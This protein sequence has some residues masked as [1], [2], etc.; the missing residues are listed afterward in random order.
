MAIYRSISDV[1]DNFF[2]GV[3]VVIPTFNQ[4]T[5]CK[6][7]IARLK[8]FG[9]NNFIILDNGSTYQPFLEWLNHS[10]Y[11]AVIDFRNPGPRDF[12]ANSEIYSRLPKNFIVTDPDLE[13]PE[14]IPI[15]LVSDLLEISKK[16]GWH[17]LGLGLSREPADKMVPLVNDWEKNYWINILAHTPSGDP[18]YEAKVDTTFA[19]YNKDFVRGPGVL[20]PEGEFFTA[21]R[22]CGKYICI[23]LGWYLDAKVPI[24]EHSYYFE[25]AAKWASTIRETKRVKYSLIAKIRFLVSRYFP[26]KELT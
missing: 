20:E 18:I 1:P 12:W 14:S 11:P 13:Y 7:T 17:K 19:L 3:P 23:H 22:I 4:L 6:N 26:F 8:D 16:N 2:Q 24:E 5:F 9:L 15:S 21:P 10:E 25:N